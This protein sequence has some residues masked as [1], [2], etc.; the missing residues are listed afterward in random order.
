MQA[1]TKPPRPTGVTILGVLSM[2]GG[3]GGLFAGA[4]LLFLAVA[5][6]LNLTSEIRDALITAGYPGLTGLGVAL[7][8]GLLYA[9]GFVFLILGVLFLAVGI[10][11]FGGRGWA[12]TLGLA[13]SIMGIVLDIIQLALGSIFWFLGVIIGFIIIYYLTRPHVKTY[14]GKGVPVTPSMTTSPTAASP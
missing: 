11:F 3:I 2:L 1:I 10:G 7:V 9:L 6:T 14:F 12:W 13:V 8:T 5:I 4:S